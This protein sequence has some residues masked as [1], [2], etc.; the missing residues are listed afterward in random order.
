VSR[1]SHDEPRRLP[2]ATDH[3]PII[4]FRNVSK[5]FW[6]R[7]KEVLALKDVSLNIGRNEFT[8]VVGPSGCGKTTLL[9]L[10]SGLEPTTEGDTIYRGK[11]VEGIN[12]DV[13]YVTQDSNLYPWMTLRQNVEFPL[14]IR[15]VAAGERKERVDAY[16]E[17]VGLEGFEDHYPYQL[18]GGMQKRGSIIRTM[19]Y[20]PRVILMDEPFGPLDAQT[21]MVLQA[22]LLRIAEVRQQTILFITHDLT[23]AIALSDKVVVMSA[24]PGVVK[25]VFSI[26]LS[27]PRDVFQIH[28]QEGFND[29]YAEIW[30]SFRSEVL[31]QQGERH[32]TRTLPPPLNSSAA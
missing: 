19:V 25:Q 32:E 22:D 10:S 27:R 28:E 29:I 7:G 13:G 5:R 30:D 3:E 14:E 23:E 24:R 8:S 6:T 16:I 20:D 11:P 26:P 12:T 1:H 18:S 21:R 15:G 31:G 17:M 4:E 9:R 2:I